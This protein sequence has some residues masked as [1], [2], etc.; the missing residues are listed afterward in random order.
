M[1]PNQDQWFSSVSSVRAHGMVWF[2][3]FGLFI[4]IIAKQAKFWMCSLVLKSHPCYLRE[5]LDV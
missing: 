3:K 1:E 4:C 2:L 5:I